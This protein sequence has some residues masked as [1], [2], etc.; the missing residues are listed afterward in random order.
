MMMTMVALEW[1]SE[2]DVAAQDVVGFL[3]QWHRVPATAVCD[4]ASIVSRP[5]GTREKARICHD[6]ACKCEASVATLLCHK[7]GYVVAGRLR[8]L[9]WG[10]E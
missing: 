3:Q 10:F 4:I 1:V 7:F 8:I 2:K 6:I 5:W 9:K